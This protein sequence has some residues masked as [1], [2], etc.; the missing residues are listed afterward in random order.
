MRGRSSRIEPILQNQLLQVSLASE[1]MSLAWKLS[2]INPKIK[3]KKIKAQ[4]KLSTHYQKYKTNNVVL[5]RPN[6]LKKD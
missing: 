4:E 1:Q 6:L 2:A 3:N 5:C